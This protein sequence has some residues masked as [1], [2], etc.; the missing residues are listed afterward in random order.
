MNFG[1]RQLARGNS[2]A[3]PRPYQLP[4]GWDALAAGQP[5]GRPRTRDVFPHGLVQGMNNTPAYRC[6]DLAVS[7]AEE[8]FALNLK[9]QF[10][11]QNRVYGGDIS[12][13]I[14]TCHYTTLA[15]LAYC[16][17]STFTMAIGANVVSIQNYGTTHRDDPVRMD[18]YT[19]CK[20][21]VL[22]YLFEYCMWYHQS[23]VLPTGKRLLAGI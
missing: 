13:Y 18:H 15:F 4:D 9:A 21:N 17:C 10:E 12:S 14:K 7:I 5:N 20:K 6:V 19:R 22:I 11:S 1:R 23:Y 3:L 2:N 16:C 8:M